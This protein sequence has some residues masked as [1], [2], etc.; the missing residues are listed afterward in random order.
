MRFARVLCLLLSAAVAVGAPSLADA[1]SRAK[2]PLRIIVPIP[3]GGQSDVVARLV[4]EALR[5]RLGQPVVVENRPGASGRIA[6]DALRSAAADGATLLFAPI[7]V[8]VLVPL[9]F[10]DVSYD[11][12]KDFAPVSQ[13]A[14]YGFAFAV[15]ADHPAQTLPEFVAWAK[16][17]SARATFGTPGAGSVPHFLGVMLRQAAGIELV[18]VAYKGAAPAEAEVLSGQIAAVASGLWDLVPLHRAGRLRILASAGA[19][20]S[21][22]LPTVPTFREQGYPAIEATGWHGVY[23]PAGT[24]PPVIDQL[25]AAIVAAVRTP[26]LGEKFAALGLEPT[27][28]TPEV[29]ASITVDDI[30]RWRPIVK[31]AGF[32]AE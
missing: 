16:A 25:S 9:V 29:L 8:P 20:R 15:A 27:G 10:K 12:Q 6:V 3:T 4:A 11:P 32:T 31:A 18:H 17:N 13:V 2:Q 24:P 5:E 19:E 30:K 1:Q 21:P 28:T 7:A 26:D 14:T 23:A 22:L